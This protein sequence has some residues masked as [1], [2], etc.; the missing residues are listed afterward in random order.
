MHSLQLGLW[1]PWP[2]PG[3]LCDLT[4]GKLAGAAYMERGERRQ[5]ALLSCAQQYVAGCIYS[6]HHDISI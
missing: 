1:L 4:G 6:C 3:G 2:L 5:L